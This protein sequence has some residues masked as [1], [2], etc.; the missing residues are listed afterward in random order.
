MHSGRDSASRL[1]HI[2]FQIKKRWSYSQTKV[3]ISNQ[4]F[5]RMSAFLKLRKS[6]TTALQP[7]LNE[8]VERVNITIIQR[9]EKVVTDH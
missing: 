7:Q 6:S 8:M 4:Y 2:P 5:S 9:L 3:R 1:K